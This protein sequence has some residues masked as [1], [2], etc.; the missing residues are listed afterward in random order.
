MHKLLMLSA[1]FC[2]FWTPALANEVWTCTF[3]KTISDDGSPIK[4]ALHDKI[5]ESLG[6]LPEIY[7]VAADNDLA[8]VAV[9]AETFDTKDVRLTL[10]S[11]Y[12]IQTNIFAIN[13]K[14]G[15]AVKGFVSLYRTIDGGGDLHG[16]CTLDH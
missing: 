1:A 13:R 10:P 12:V 3:P 14:T 6:S 11:R 8:I 15:E 5:L 4:Y 2:L 7:Q 9:S 16:R